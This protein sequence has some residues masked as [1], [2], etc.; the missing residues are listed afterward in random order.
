ME[1]EPEIRLLR[2]VAQ[3]FTHCI[4]HFGY[5]T[6]FKGGNL[7]RSL[8][9]AGRLTDLCCY[10]KDGLFISCLGTLRQNEFGLVSSLKC[11]LLFFGNLPSAMG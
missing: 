11:N 1:S 6:V 4:H 7:R 2:L 9:H 3:T 10:C 5:A 8:V